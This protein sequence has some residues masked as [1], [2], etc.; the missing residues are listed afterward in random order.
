MPA[1]AIRAEQPGAQQLIAASSAA[2]RLTQPGEQILK[3]ETRLLPVFRRICVGKRGT[4]GI[5]DAPAKDGGCTCREID[6]FLGEERYMY[7]RV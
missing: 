4:R 6:R 3:Y 7:L 1:Q 5:Y 2:N